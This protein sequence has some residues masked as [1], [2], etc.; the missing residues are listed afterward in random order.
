MIKPNADYLF[1]ASWEVCNKAGGINTVIKTKAPYML[2]YYTNYFLVGPYFKEKADVE[3]QTA[4]P[5]AI[6]PLAAHLSR[7]FVRCPPA[8]HP[9]PSPTG[10]RG[11]PP[12]WSPGDSLQR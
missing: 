2:D 7:R 12:E 10:L 1:E 11:T 5:P 3:F 9:L 6:P 4:E 8:G